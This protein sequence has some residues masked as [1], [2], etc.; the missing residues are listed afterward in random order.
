MAR[1]F[2]TQ[3]NAS[4]IILHRAIR[5]HFQL[6]DH[7][8]VDFE[9]FDHLV[10]KIVS[11][12][13]AF[14][15]ME[16]IEG[17]SFR[18]AQMLLSHK[19]PSSDEGSS[20]DKKDQAKTDMIKAMLGKGKKKTDPEEEWVSPFGVHFPNPNQKSNYGFYHDTYCPETKTY[21]PGPNTGTSDSEDLLWKALSDKHAVN[22]A[23]SFIPSFSGGFCSSCTFLLLPYLCDDH[24][25]VSLM[26]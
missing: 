12:S 10:R 26:L 3:V 8:D 24:Q 16:T 19:W 25:S 11:L 17:I 1:F 9:M 2:C 5:E 18:Q 6:K 7:E 14:T 21:A 4:D 23:S 22:E 13:Q 15:G 20:D